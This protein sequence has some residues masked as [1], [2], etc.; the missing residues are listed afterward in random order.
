MEQPR[1]MDS[2]GL[3]RCFIDKPYSVSFGSELQRYLSFLFAECFKVF[4]VFFVYLLF[5]QAC[6]ESL[7]RISQTFGQS[8][9]ANLS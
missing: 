3:S 8:F 6:F 4:I 9:F 1:R 7:P 2:R 5:L